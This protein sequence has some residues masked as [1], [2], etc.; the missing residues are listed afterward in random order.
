MAYKNEV[1][2]TIDKE[3]SADCC[4]PVAESSLASAGAGYSLGCI[5]EVFS[6]PRLN[7]ARVCPVEKPEAHSF[8]IR[9]KP[10]TIKLERS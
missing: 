3:K 8:F 9:K 4:A 5:D 10:R 7:R 6:T 1:D 2:V